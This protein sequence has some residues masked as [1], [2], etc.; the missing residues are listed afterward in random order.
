M[1]D[2]CPCCRRP[3]P[4]TNDLVIDS[5]IVVCNGRVAALTIQENALLEILAA[6]KGRVQS[7]ERLL[8]SLYALQPDDPPEIKIIDVFV[9]KLRKKLKPLGVEIFTVRGQGYRL[10]PVPERKVA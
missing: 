5:G 3:L 1:T 8:A 2:L 10:L 6:A 9:C 4:E 7:K